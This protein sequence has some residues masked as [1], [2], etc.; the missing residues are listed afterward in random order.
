MDTVVQPKRVLLIVFSGT[1]NTL[2]A[3]ELIRDSFAKS[4]VSADILDSTRAEMPVNTEGYDLVGLGY[5]VYAFNTPLVFLQ[6]VKK[7]ALRNKRVFIFK[8]SGEPGFLNDPSSHALKKL[9][10]DCTLLG[11]YH[12]LM[13]YN[14]IFRFPDNLVKQMYVAAKQLSGMLTANIIEGRTSFIRYNL[15]QRFVSCIFKIQRPGAYLNG[16][17]YGVNRKRCS[18]CL[19]CVRDC[20]AQNIRMVK[21]RLRFGWRCVMCMRCAFRCPHDALRIGFL[22]NWRVN[23]PFHFEALEKDP[24]LDG[25]FISEKTRGLYRM[26]LPWFKGLN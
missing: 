3:A 8:T 16:R 11:D 25:V 12:F 9:L 2:A 14:I 21:N 1:G 15:F 5:P 19:V 23:G 10:R 17:L 7:L 20:P 26:Y 13:P 18:L 24:A 6:F 22:N 4:G